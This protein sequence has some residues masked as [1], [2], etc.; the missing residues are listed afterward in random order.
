M[1]AAAQI[2]IVP[3]DQ[4]GTQN[5]WGKILF[6]DRRDIARELP[7]RTVAL[8]AQC[9]DG[10]ELLLVGGRGNAFGKDPH[11]VRILQGVSRST[12]SAHDIVI[13]PLPQG[14]SQPPWPS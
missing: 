7:R 5:G 2:T 4:Q 9:T 1:I 3:E 6:G 13:Q 10:L 12:V 11:H 8:A 14:P